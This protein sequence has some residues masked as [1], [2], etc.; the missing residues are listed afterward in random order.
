MSNDGPEIAIFKFMEAIWILLLLLARSGHTPVPFFYPCYQAPTHRIPNPVLY[1]H[2]VSSHEE[3]H[4]SA[5]HSVA[6]SDF[7]NSIEAVGV[8]YANLF[9]I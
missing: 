6:N 8:G 2:S 7:S 5:H 3:D 1:D 9:E 4:R